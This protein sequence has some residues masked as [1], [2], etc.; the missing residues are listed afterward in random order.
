MPLSLGCSHSLPRVQ[1]PRVTRASAKDRRRHQREELSPSGCLKSCFHGSADVSARKPTPPWPPDVRRGHIVRGR[2]VAS[3]R[4]T[5]KRRRLYKKASIELPNLAATILSS[6]DCAVGRG[7]T[8][9]GGTQ[10][11]HSV[12]GN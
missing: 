7:R 10:H 12:R 2:R 5:L 9:S 11:R 3:Q 4:R 1:L 6:I 8:D